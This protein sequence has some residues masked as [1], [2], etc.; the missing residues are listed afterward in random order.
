MSPRPKQRSVLVVD[1]DHTVRE[2]L[3]TM[4]AQW[5]FE[6]AT[7]MNGRHGLE[8]V[9]QLRPALVIT[10]LMMPVMEGAEFIRELH[11]GE[12]TPKIIAMS[13]SVER[14]AWGTRRS[15]PVEGADITI[16]KPFYPAELRDAVSRL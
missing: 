11:R 16:G 12:P 8:L 2:L 3:Q 9:G 10:D 1:D 15:L 6:V 7:A 13:V 4:L 14:T 5:G